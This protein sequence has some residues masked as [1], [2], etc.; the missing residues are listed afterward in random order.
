M[1]IKNLIRY[2]L[3]AWSGLLLFGC[4]A[5]PNQRAQES[6]KASK[7][8]DSI[9][10]AMEFEKDSLSETTLE[11]FEKRATQKLED[12]AD[13]IQILSDSSIDRS[14]RLQARQMLIAVFEK[15]TNTIPFDLSGKGELKK[16]NTL[17]FADSLLSDRYSRLKVEIADIETLKALSLKGKKTYEGVLSFTQKVYHYQQ[18]T[19]IKLSKYNMEVV[20]V[21]KRTTKRFGTSTKKIWEVLLRDIKI[22]E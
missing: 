2:C 12:A 13:Y 17:Q 20:I 7:M 8:R 19:P 14:F 1:K 15:K 21:V 5:S 10:V 11:A 9:S 6:I 4:G 16:L 22:V 3:I 18:D